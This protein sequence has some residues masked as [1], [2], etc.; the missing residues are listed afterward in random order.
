M[1][2]P[3][4]VFPLMAPHARHRGMCTYQGESGLCV[5]ESAPP[6]Q[7]RHGMTRA[8]ICPDSG[9]SVRRRDRRFIVGPMTVV[10]L[11][12]DSGIRVFLLIRVTGLA[13]G[14][15]VRPRSAKR[16]EI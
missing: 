14:K 8:A 7:R 9:C 13:L 6:G 12:R 11:Q 4:V 3:G 10:A 2:K 15:P 1:R 16:V 5:V